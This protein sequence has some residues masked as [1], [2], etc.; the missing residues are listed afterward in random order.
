MPFFFLKPSVKSSIE[1][2]RG[3]C[4]HILVDVDGYGGV[5]KND[6][7]DLVP[8]A[9]KSAL[10]HLWVILWCTHIGPVETRVAVMFLALVWWCQLR[11]CI[12]CT[13]INVVTS[14]RQAAHTV[15]LTSFALERHGK[16]REK[17]WN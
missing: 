4:Y 17:G 7:H 10:D 8:Q 9:M 14:Y 13:D 5:T 1:E 15:V 12:G 2:I 3:S 11:V 6:L 16:W